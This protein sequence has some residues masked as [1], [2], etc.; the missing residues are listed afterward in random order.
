MDTRILSALSTAG[1]GLTVK[2]L[3]SQLRPFY[4]EDKDLK[5]SINSLLYTVLLKSKRVEKHA[6]LAGTQAPVWRVVDS[7]VVTFV[8]LATTTSAELVEARELANVRYYGELGSPNAPTTAV[9]CT[10]HGFKLAV[11]IAEEKCAGRKVRVFSQHAELQA[12]V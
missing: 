6:P 10:G 1:E 7:G 9:L 11:A 8:D 2:Q 3:T 5:S 4:P 12:L